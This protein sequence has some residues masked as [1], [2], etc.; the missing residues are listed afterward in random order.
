MR[1]TP[2]TIHSAKGGKMIYFSGFSAHWLMMT[3]FDTS[4]RGVYDEA[5]FQLGL[6]FVIA[7]ARRHG[8]YLL[9]CLTYNFDDFGGK[10]QYVRWAT[11]TGH[12]LTA[13]ADD[14]FSST[15]VKDSRATTRTEEPRHGCR[16]RLHHHPPPTSTRT[17]GSR[18]PPPTSRPASSGTGCGRAG[19]SLVGGAFWK[20]LLDDDDMD[21]LRDGYEIIL[22]EDTRAA[23]IIG[24][25]SE[26]S[27]DQD[28]SSG[29]DKLGSPTPSSP[30][31]P[32]SVCIF[33]ASRPDRSA[34]CRRTVY[35]SPRSS[36][37]ST[38]SSIASTSGCKRK[39]EEDH[40]EAPVCSAP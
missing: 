8:V 6:D 13:G 9:L 39:A 24:N 2:N 7:E 10:R 14:F 4:S 21:D 35:R 17:S 3:A 25:H 27:S 15:V 22:P 31:I 29:A 26:Q 18:A 16:D 12:N 38:A 20:L 36:S 19:G 37:S 33:L 5:M 23:S 28:P 11:D 32:R 30:S 1:L 40:P 34:H